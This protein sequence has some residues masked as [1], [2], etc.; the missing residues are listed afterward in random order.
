MDINEI[1]DLLATKRIGWQHAANE[2]L[3]A[4]EFDEASELD[5]KCEAIREFAATLRTVYILRQL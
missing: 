2:A 4:G 5:T 3:K 1:M